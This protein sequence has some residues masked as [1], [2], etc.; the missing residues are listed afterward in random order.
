MF[1][2]NLA[3][4]LCQLSNCRRCYFHT[5]NQFSISPLHLIFTERTI[6]KVS[7]PI[8][9]QKLVGLSLDK[10]NHHNCTMVNSPEKA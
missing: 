1:G 10:E 2:T 8:A 3:Y 6:I 7:M 9:E 4:L 5:S